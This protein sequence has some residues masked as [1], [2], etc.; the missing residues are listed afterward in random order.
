MHDE[1]AA[2]TRQ[3]HLLVADLAEQVHALAR[4]FSHRLIQLA[5]RQTLF[6]RPA[7]RLLR[8]E[9][10][11]GGDE[12][13]DALVRAEK[14]V[15]RDKVR[16]PLARVRQILRLCALP[17]FAAD[18]L[19]QPL[20]LAQGLRVVCSCDDVLDAF[21][22]EHLLKLALAA[23][24]EVLPALVGEHFLG[25][26]KARDAVHQGFDHELCALLRR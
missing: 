17:E 14:V 3:S 24:G 15:V 7:Q 9:E 5:R 4:R 12:P 6:V 22:Q 20:A 18:R 21:A 11:I 25:F 10:S 8:P 13:T 16:K 26:A 2:L 23:P 1:L 19:P